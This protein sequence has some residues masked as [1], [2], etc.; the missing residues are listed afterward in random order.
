[1]DKNISVVT[2]LIGNLKNMAIDIGNEIVI[3][4]QLIDHVNMKVG[5]LLFSIVF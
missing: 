1:M 4:N 2:Q 5:L 3:Q